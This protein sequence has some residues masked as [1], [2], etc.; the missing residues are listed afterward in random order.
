[1][2]IYKQYDQEAL[3]RQYTNRLHVPDF[4]THIDTWESLSRQTEK[5][6]PVVKDIAYGKLSREQLDIYPSPEP[7]SKTLVFIHGGY[8]HKFDKA[9]SQFIAKAF[10]IYGIT[11][12]IINY[13]LA[14]AVS[15]DQILLS[16]REAIHWLYK[17]ISGYNGDPNQIYVA[18]HSAGAHLAAMLLATDPIA[19]GWKQYDLPTDVIKGVCVI[20]GVFNLIPIQLSYL[21]EVL[22]MDTVTAIRN[23]PVQ[24]SPANGCPLLIAVGGDE[25]DE[26]VDQSHELYNCW[27]ESIPA[28]IIQIPGLNHFSIIETVLDTGSKLHQVMRRLM[29][30]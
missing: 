15:M 26:F 1:M 5:E 28:E 29:K 11:T 3:D 20:S 25:T 4:A 6:Y 19:I 12:V 2:P 27:K 23:S 8:W 7:S 18:G 14:P 9:D 10:R 30:I 22:N 13:P 17:N 16:C 21:N 24:L